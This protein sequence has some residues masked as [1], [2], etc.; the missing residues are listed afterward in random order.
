MSINNSQGLAQQNLEME[1]HFQAFPQDCS[2][3][4]NRETT[5]R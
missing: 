1:Q 4:G 2:S 5:A 3:S